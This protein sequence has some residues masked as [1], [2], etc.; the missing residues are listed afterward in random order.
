[1][2]GG[3]GSKKVT[4][5]PGPFLAFAWNSPERITSGLPAYG[6]TYSPG[7]MSNFRKASITSSSDG[8]LAKSLR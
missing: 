1:M 6:I 3:P 4:N 5:A 7:G 2:A 8:T